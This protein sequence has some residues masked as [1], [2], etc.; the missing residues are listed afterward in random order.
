MTEDLQ[1]D[2]RRMLF[3]Q[4]RFLILDQFVSATN[5]RRVSM[6]Y[7]F[8]WYAQVFPML[9]H[10]APWHE[11]HAAA[12]EVSEQALLELVCFLEQAWR[13]RRDLSFV[14][15][16]DRFQVHGGDDDTEWTRRTLAAAC[17]YLWLKGQFDKPFWARLTGGPRCPTEAREICT[18]FHADEVYFS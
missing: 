4:Q 6:P 16:E 17:R 1:D 11:P 9:H 2:L 12:F 7:A 8:A 13:S 5:P 18:D 14:D 3:L 15:L 10:S